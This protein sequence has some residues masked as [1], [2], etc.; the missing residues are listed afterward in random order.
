VEAAANEVKSYFS[1]LNSQFGGNVLLELSYDEKNTYNESYSESH[2]GIVFV[3]KFYVLISDGSMEQGECMEN[4]R[5]TVHYNNYYGKWEL[6]SYG[7][8]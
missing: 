8:G 4:W 6:V 7:Y 3:S 1:S 2:T 5:W